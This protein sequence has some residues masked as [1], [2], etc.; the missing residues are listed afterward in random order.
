MSK[1][2]IIGAVGGG[3]YNAE[4]N[5][6]VEVIEFN[7]ERFQLRQNDIENIDLP[8]AEQALADA[9]LALAEASAALDEA[10]RQLEGK[11]SDALF[12]ALNAA[13]TALSN[14]SGFL[15]N[16]QTGLINVS[17]F[18]SAAS[19]DL[20]PSPDP[21]SVAAISAAGTAT[22]L[23]SGS[24]NDEANEVSI[25]SSQLSS[26]ISSLQVT[27]PDLSQ[28]QD[29]I[30]ALLDQLNTVVNAHVS[31]SSDIN[32]AQGQT[33]AARNTLPGDVSYDASR[34][35][36]DN[37][38]LAFTTTSASHTAANGQYVIAQDRVGIAQTLLLPGGTDSRNAVKNALTAL[39]EASKA[40]A[41]AAF[42]V[43][44]LNLEFYGLERKI[45]K[46]Q[47]IPRSETK[48][49]WIADLTEDLPSAT[50]VGTMEIPGEFGGPQSGE[51]VIRPAFFHEHLFSH[52]RDG[53]ITPCQAQTPAATYYNLAM[54]PGWQVFRPT[55]RFARV[56]AING[57]GTLK[58]SLISPNISSQQTID[59]TPKD[60]P[61]T[62]SQSPQTVNYDAVAVQYMDCDAAAFA[63]GDEVVVEYREQQAIRPR[64]IGFRRNPQPCDV[65]FFSPQGRLRVVNDAWQFTPQTGLEFGNRDWRG[66]LSWWSIREDGPDGIEEN[67]LAWRDI[68]LHPTHPHESNKLYW[69]GETLATTPGPILGASYVG[70]TITAMV[71][72]DP[73]IQVYVADAPFVLWTPMQSQEVVSPALKP[74]IWDFS[75]NGQRA[76]SVMYTDDED[77][78]NF[79]PHLFSWSP[80]AGFVDEGRQGGFH[81]G[82]AYRLLYRAKIDDEGAFKRAFGVAPE[83][84][85]SSHLDVDGEPP[86]S[87]VDG[88]DTDR[89][90]SVNYIDLRPE[91]SVVAGYTIML[92]APPTDAYWRIRTKGVTTEKGNFVQA[93]GNFSTDDPAAEETSIA[94]DR[95]GNIIIADGKSE[96]NLMVRDGDFQLLTGAL[97]YE[98][99]IGRG[100]V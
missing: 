98:P 77:T 63:V 23:A 13:D 30:I 67:A 65:F 12:A 4:M 31:A 55:F 33:Q 56:T 64:V 100:S 87:V 19:A 18:I 62:P 27:E 50:V 73:N 71:W 15:T 44:S 17:T 81:T 47:D 41:A 84:G 82:T 69:H 2:T 49:L 59:V 70:G 94:S 11:P 36:L 16:T 91:Q 74:G 79:I 24:V 99:H 20:P 42:A 7:I 72:E 83:P 58:V 10:I 85:D 75:P 68:A 96:Q 95:D 66:Q 29:D 1:A 57:D 34:A 46:L 53:W 22:G 21:P 54:L 37:A 76:C 39:N 43:D 6:N 40:R 78:P 86:L 26:L 89:V 90:R 14:A 35:D 3:L 38:L 51:A 60:L 32:F 9:D 5:F 61:A 88:P 28:A 80:A 52:A 92:G 45:G 93:D 25:A 97:E 48:Q 8:A